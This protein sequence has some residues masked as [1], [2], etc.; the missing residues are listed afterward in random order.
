MTIHRHSVVGSVMFYPK[1]PGLCGGVI[2]KVRIAPASPLNFVI[3]VA[4]LLYPLISLKKLQYEREHCQL[5]IV[6]CLVV[7]FVHTK[8]K[9][10]EQATPPVSSLP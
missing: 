8:P 2:I 5:S 10:D 3:V 4:F 9:R 6:Y 1:E 7:A